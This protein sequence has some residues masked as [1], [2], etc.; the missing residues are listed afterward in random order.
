MNKKIFNESF[1]SDIQD[2]RSG[3]DQPFL[4]IQDA[5]HTDFAEQL[6]DALMASDAWEKSDPSSFSKSERS[7]IPEGY[8]FTREIINLNRPGLPPAVQKLF[9][10]L[11]SEECLQWFSQVSG[12][13]CDE[14]TGACARYYGGNHLTSHNDYYMKR[15]DDGSVAT[16]SLTFNYYL[17][18]DW[19]AEWGGN[20]VWEKPYTKVTPTFNTLVLFAVGHDTMHHVEQVNDG[21]S[22]PRLAFTG[23]FMTNRA[24][25]EH[26]LDL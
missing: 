20:F 1:T 6:Y 16:R 19:D 11:N 9:D 10:H 7:A 17:T 12:R 18:K 14:F 5:L 3:P 25:G 2:V 26:V 24:S 15:Q 23:W 21:V 4:I 13:R 8:S 22:S